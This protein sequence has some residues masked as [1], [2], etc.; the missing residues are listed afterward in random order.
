ML[1]R[2]WLG[3][4]TLLVTF[5]CCHIDSPKEADGPLDS[6][7][8]PQVVWGCGWFWVMVWGLF[9][10]QGMIVVVSVGGRVVCSV[11][12][13]WG[14]WCVGFHFPHVLGQGGSIRGERPHCPCVVSFHQ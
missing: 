4:T 13:G 3:T 14:V 2:G 1:F 11:F 7:D 6:R 8:L 9:K 12:K 5:Y 10:H